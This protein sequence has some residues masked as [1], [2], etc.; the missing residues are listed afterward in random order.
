MS[1]PILPIGQLV[2]LTADGVVK[3]GPCTVL[4]VLV[5]GNHTD[6]N[7][8]LHNDVDSAGGT[9]VIEMG[10]E[11]EGGQTFF[12]FTNLGGVAFSVGCYGDYT[13]TTAFMYVWI[14]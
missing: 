13:G 12:D 14:E 10:G 3:A 9:Q 5:D 11:A 4:A 2:R 6:W 8:K 1:K 7:L